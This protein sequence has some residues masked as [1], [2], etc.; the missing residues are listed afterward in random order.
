MTASAN[1]ME[2]FFNSL[3]S[4]SLGVSC[5]NTSFQVSNNPP[6]TAT[7]TFFD[8]QNLD[9]NDSGGVSRLVQNTTG[10]DVYITQLNIFICDGSH[11]IVWNQWF[12]GDQVHHVLDICSSNN[13]YPTDQ[14]RV[15]LEGQ[16]IVDL[17]SRYDVKNR[18]KENSGTP[19]HQPS[20]TQIAFNPPVLC[21]KDNYVRVWRDGNNSALSV[22]RYGVIG[23]Y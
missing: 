15:F 4:F 16:N 8:F 20:V 18:I 3:Q 12:V 19:S 13:D 17:W 6:L 7:P 1:D 10:S 9:V 22:L 2:F 5:A 11:D 23:Y 21:E 14:V